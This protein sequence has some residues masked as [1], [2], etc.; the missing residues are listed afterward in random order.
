MA[1]RG[2]ASM[3]N[4]RPVV[5]VWPASELAVEQAARHAQEVRRRNPQN[6]DVSLGRS[7]D[8]TQRRA[9]ID[10][11]PLLPDGSNEHLLSSPCWVAGQPEHRLICR[12][13]PPGQRYPG[14]ARAACQ[15]HTDD[16]N[17]ERAMQNA[18]L[19][20]QACGGARRKFYRTQP[21]LCSGCVRRE[22]LMFHGGAIPPPVGWDASA[23][24]G[25]AASRP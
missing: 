25:G 5:P 21:D 10:E 11:T 15:S 12:S 13:V 14:H 4:R 9:W 17:T 23:W 19:A 22:T 3:V 1:H 6:I 7:A 8:L 2:A 24:P 16:T 18:A 20:R